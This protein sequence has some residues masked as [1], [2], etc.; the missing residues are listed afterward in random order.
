MGLLAYLTWDLDPEIIKFGDTFALRWYGVCFASGFL[1]G[2]SIM[3]WI[4]QQE[5]K[6]EKDL[7]AMCVALV[8][9]TI[10]GARLGHCFLYDFHHYMTHP[11]EILQVW[12]GG[13]A[14]HGGALGV[15]IALWI[16]AKKR[17]EQPYGWVVDRVA[18]PTALAAALIRLGN[19]FNSEIV[20]TATDVPWAIIFPRAVNVADPMAPRHPAQLYEALGYLITFALMFYLYKRRKAA[21]P[22][23]LLTGWFLVCVFTTRILVEFFKVRQA[24]FAAD[25]PVSWGQILSVP[26]VIAG[27]WLI[28]RAIKNGPPVVATG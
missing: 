8:V 25:W 14:S 13:L 9:G 11:L 12:K 28:R 7:D 1:I 21:T 23:G 15:V 16:Y 24:T 2:F 10:V 22:Y 27:A 3:K 4:F 20:G 18:V 6:P 17:P 5:D 26:F 19:F